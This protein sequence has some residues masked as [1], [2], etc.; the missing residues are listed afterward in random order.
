MKQKR[1]KVYNLYCNGDLIGECLWLNEVKEMIRE[2][3]KFYAERRII[4]RF[5]WF[6][7]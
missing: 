3:K 7:V 2:Y 6:E 5:E 4:P 1:L